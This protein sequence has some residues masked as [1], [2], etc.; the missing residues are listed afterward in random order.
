ME[1]AFRSGRILVGKYRIDSLLGRDGM[2]LVFTATHL[3][4]AQPVVVKILV[5]ETVTSLAVHARFLREAQSIA[6]LSGEHVAR[7]IDVGILP[8]G[9]PYS[10]MEALHG[11]DLASEIARRGVLMPGEAVDYILQACEALAEAHAHGIV[12]G[13]IKPANVFFTARPDGTVF[14]KVLG[15]EGSRN[16]NGQLVARPDAA[17]GTPG[18]MAPE[19]MRPTEELDGRADV[20]ALGIVLYQCITVRHPFQAFQAESGS[21]MQQ[22]AATESP[23]PM[24]PGIPRPLQAVVLRCLEKGR[25]ARFPSIA[26]LAAALAPFAHDQGAAAAI[27]DRASFMS[28]GL[29]GGFEVAPPGQYPIIAPPTVP[30]GF[31][32]SRSRRRY[33][34]IGLAVLAVSLSGIAAAALIGPDRSPAESPGD[35]PTASSTT[36]AVASAGKPAPPAS[37]A[38]DSAAAKPAP[39]TSPAADSA[40]AKSTPPTSPAADPAAAKP[41]SANRPAADAT[42]ATS[43]PPAGSAAARPAKASTEPP[44][45]AAAAAKQPAAERPTERAARAASAKAPAAERSTAAPSP[46]SSSRPKRS[47]SCDAMDVDELMTRAAIQYDAGS[48]TSALSFT[49]VALGCKQTERMYWLAV[50]YACAAHDLANARLYFP[51]VPANLQSGLETKCQRENL[52]VRSR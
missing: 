51:K 39:P 17:A 31:S 50:M 26:D 15:F 1:G 23:R 24:D 30:A 46:P 20:W 49:R 43:T 14:V 25:D 9:V 2:C 10:V 40:A 34:V 29:G 28:H 44:D 5:P 41:A 16:A 38:T 19:Q 18:Y 13:D 6:R 45:E 12:H 32:Q 33:A 4:V 47:D 48:A 42:A 21:L 22:A 37:P 27:V 36:P 8:E 52:D 3:Q 11:I 7:I 35:K